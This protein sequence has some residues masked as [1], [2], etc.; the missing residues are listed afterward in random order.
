[1]RL[2]VRP[3][4]VLPHARGPFVFP[5]QQ[6]QSQ[7]IGIRERSQ[8]GTFRFREKNERAHSFDIEIIFLFELLHETL[9]QKTGRQI[10]V[11]LF[12]ALPRYPLGLIHLFEIETS[13]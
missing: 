8:A 13:E 4:S 12:S 1:M 6:E 11:R 9:R 3:S 2:R 7:S 10:S 5:K